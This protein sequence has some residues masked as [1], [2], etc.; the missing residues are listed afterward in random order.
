MDKLF[1][2]RAG[3]VDRK[4]SIASIAGIYSPLI[5]ILAAALVLF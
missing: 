4:L 3:S 2:I 1:T 5:I